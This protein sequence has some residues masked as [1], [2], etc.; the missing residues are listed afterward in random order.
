MPVIE[1]RLADPS[2]ENDFDYLRLTMNR[3]LTCKITTCGIVA[4]SL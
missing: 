3:I 1:E 2:P 4:C